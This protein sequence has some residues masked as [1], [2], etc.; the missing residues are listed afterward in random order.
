[1]KVIGTRKDGK[2]YIRIKG[3]YEGR[4]V[5]RMAR[6]FYDETVI[7][8]LQNVVD[9]IEG[10][11][12]G[13]MP[14]QRSLVENVKELEGGQYKLLVNCGLIEE[15]K[16]EVYYLSNCL[17]ACVDSD[18][19]AVKGNTLTEDTVRKRFNTALLFIK[20][21]NRKY[22]RKIHVKKKK[23]RL[24]DSNFDIRK[25]TVKDGRKFCEFMQL[26]EGYS[27]DTLLGKVKQI[28]IFIT[29]TLLRGLRALIR[30]MFLLYIKN[31]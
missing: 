30:Q 16:A 14:W 8:N 9:K 2:S 26:D 19:R 22:K 24:P 15:E 31:H 1:M 11:S 13:G 7:R 28:R 29:E 3:Q 10:Y 23:F 25:L 20:F 4:Q 27:Y 21:V 12:Q 5:D 18:I 17:Q 6:C